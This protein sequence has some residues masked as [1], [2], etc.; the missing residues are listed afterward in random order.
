MQGRQ[1]QE[2]NAAC[3]CGGWILT[4]SNSHFALRPQALGLGYDAS[5]M[6][7]S[8]PRLELLM[9]A[10]GQPAIVRQPTG[11]AAVDRNIQQIATTQV[12]ELLRRVAAL[13]GVLRADN[14]SDWDE[15]DRLA[16][17]LLLADLAV[18][19]S[20]T[21]ALNDLAA[22][23]LAEALSDLVTAGREVERSFS[24]TR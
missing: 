3:P 16:A 12:D 8:N 23:R 24:D 22:A 17:Q 9:A 10:I 4:T 2:A 13:T 18:I 15:I 20:T 14:R 11:D 6:N 7:D 21:R 19:T 1:R 5:E